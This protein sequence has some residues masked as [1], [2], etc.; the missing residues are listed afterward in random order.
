[1]SLIRELMD[2]ALEPSYAAAAERRRVAGQPAA[3]SFNTSVVFVVA[4][5]VGLLMAIAGQTLRAAATVT[6]GS[7]ERLIT[8]IEGQQAHGDEQSAKAAAI[9]KEITG[10]QAAALG[11]G[12]SALLDALRLL[13]L[14]TGT[15]AVS[16]PGVV[17]TLDD[18]ADTS[19]SNA[20]PRGESGFTANRVRSTDL[21]IV[22]NG[23]WAA[24]AE[25]ISVNGQRLTTQSAIR[26]AG[27]AILV[28]FRALTRPYVITAIGDPGPLQAGFASSAAGTYVKALEQ[29]YGIPWSLQ[30][31]DRGL[32]CP[33]S[34]APELRYAEPMPGG[35]PSSSPTG[36]A[37][38]APTTPTH[39][40]RATEPRR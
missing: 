36:T 24:G 32:T 23:L 3:R 1:M 2:G 21:Q 5:V 22:V 12:Q 26:F 8:Q 29:N 28:D 40:P 14:R 31:A 19:G 38:P 9:E 11:P 13:Q 16:G 33:A 37:T 25:A 20:D 35:I 34:P 18:A 6:S 4:V 17:V 10:L 30:T 15:V 27:Q 7:G 39:T